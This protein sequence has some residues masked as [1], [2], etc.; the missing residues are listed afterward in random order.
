MEIKTR[1]NVSKKVRTD[2]TMGEISIF[3]FPGKNFVKDLNF[4]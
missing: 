3:S 4:N 1:K 2:L